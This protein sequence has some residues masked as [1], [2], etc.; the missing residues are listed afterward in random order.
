[1]GNFADLEVH[2]SNSKHFRSWW[3]EWKRHM[4]CASTGT[5][6]AHLDLMISIEEV[7][8][9]TFIFSTILLRKSLLTNILNFSRTLKTLLHLV[10]TV[11]PSCICDR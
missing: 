2:P 6:M 8:K 5:F 10:T 7:Y 1:M 11:E 4:F 3:S 9:L